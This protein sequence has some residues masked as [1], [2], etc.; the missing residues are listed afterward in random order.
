MARVLALTRDLLFGSQVQGALTL[1][2]H[3]VELIADEPRLRRQLA[4]ND[5]SARPRVEVLVVDLTDSELEGA[6]V[7][8]ALAGE[9]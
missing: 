3:D 4:G 6:A 7:V 2:G 1:A 9:G 8:E 5:D